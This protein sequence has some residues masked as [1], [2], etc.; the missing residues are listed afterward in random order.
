METHVVDH[1][2]RQGDGVIAA[3]DGAIYA[4][5]TLPGETVTGRREGDR[6]TDIVI[7]RP[8]PRRRQPVCRHFGVCGGCAIQHADEALVAEW[9]TA[10]IAQAL[11]ARG[12]A[13]TLRPI[14]VMPAGA[15]RRVVFAGR[16]T[17]KTT[18]VGFHGHASSTLAPVME[19]P[20]AAPEIVA[21]LAALAEI[22]GLVASRSGEARL[23][24]TLCET[25]LDVA[26]EGQRPMDGAL[27]DALSTIAKQADL[28]RLT[29]D[30]D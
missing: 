11:A 4:P 19:C 22:T 2:G 24:V 5:L 20:V 3:P 18:L 12:L 1:L 14:I 13:T 10:T 8:S 21:A 29:Y 30:G 25:G 6:L 9:K 26:V 7:D 17:R 15:R 28:A 16:R 27:F 23:T